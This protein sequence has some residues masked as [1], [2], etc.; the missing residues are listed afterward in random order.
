VFVSFASSP[1]S[2]AQWQRLGSGDEFPIV[3]VTQL[4]RYVTAD[5]DMLLAS[6]CGRGAWTLFNV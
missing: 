4:R 1:S 5:T 2:G 3:F 6:T